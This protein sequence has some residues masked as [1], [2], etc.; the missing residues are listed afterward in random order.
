MLWIVF[1][2]YTE[3]IIYYQFL[4]WFLQY[5]TILSTATW[6]SPRYT[7]QGIQMHEQ[8]LH[9]TLLTAPG[10]A[11]G[12]HP[13]SFALRSC[14]AW[15]ATLLFRQ[16]AYLLHYDLERSMGNRRA[17]E[18]WE[19]VLTLCEQM[20]VRTADSSGKSDSQ[21]T[22]TQAPTANPA[23]GS[24]SNLCFHFRYTTCSQPHAST[25]GAHLPVWKSC[26]QNIGPHPS[27]FRRTSHFAVWNGHE[28]CPLSMWNGLN[29]IMS[30]D[31][32]SFGHCVIIFVGETE[33]HHVALT[34][35]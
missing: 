16:P 34:G 24:S 23:G 8:K 32:F 29:S 2:C 21:V 1:T 12:A 19:R 13:P 20:C 18:Q 14:Q 35:L 25:V 26:A 30:T 27:N 28:L 5:P 31:C 33:S 4:V 10:A 22:H 7:A 9:S 15:E 11:L 6:A 3:H 17:S